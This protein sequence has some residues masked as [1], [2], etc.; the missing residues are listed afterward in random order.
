M[1][2][3]PKIPYVM[4]KDKQQTIAMGSINYSKMTQDGD[5]ADSSGISGRYFPYI[6]TAKG[7]SQVATTDNCVSATIFDE[8][9]AQVNEAGAL[10]YDGKLVGQLE[11]NE[12]Q[13]AAINTKLVIMPDKRY[14]DISGDKPVLKDMGAELFV[15]SPVFTENSLDLGNYYKMAGKVEI[16]VFD[17]FDPELRFCA[18][19]QNNVQSNF[20]IGIEKIPEKDQWRIAFMK[21]LFY[22]RVS[23]KSFGGDG[24]GTEF[25][26][27]DI[28]NTQISSPHEVYITDLD[29][30]KSGWYFI[31][32]DW[33][34]SGTYTLDKE[35]NLLSTNTVLDRKLQMWAIDHRS[36]TDM[37]TTGIRKMKIGGRELFVNVENAGDPAWGDYSIYVSCSSFDGSK[38]TPGI[39][40]VEKM[41]NGGWSGDFTNIMQ[42]DFIMQLKFDS[43]CVTGKVLTGSLKRNE[44]ALYGLNEISET[45][46][47]VF[48]KT[49]TLNS[50]VTLSEMGDNLLGLNI[51]VPGDTVIVTEPPGGANEFSFRIDTISP[52]GKTCYASSNVFKAMHFNGPIKI[53][54]RIPN[55]DYICEHDNRLYG[56]SIADNMIYASAMGDP[57]NFYAYTGLTTGSET[58]V[59]ASEGQFTACCPYDGGVMF[60]KSDKL[61]KLLGSSPLEYAIYTYNIDGVQQGSHK[62]LQNINEV[63][64][65]KGDRGVFAFDGSPRLISENFGDKHFESAV[66]GSN[67]ERYYVSMIDKDDRSHFFSYNTRTGLWVREGDRKVSS[68]TRSGKDA[69]MLESGKIKLYGAEETPMDA[70][71]YIQFTPIY[72]TIEGKKSY[73]RIK[74]RAHLPRGSYMEISVRCDG[75]RWAECGK[76]VGKREGIVPVMVPVNRC[77]KFELK[78]SGKGPCTIHSILREYYVGGDR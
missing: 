61:H 41:D 74:L 77:D 73:S 50:V 63:L 28:D 20:Y 53:E 8:K 2:K 31:S 43:Y 71:W 14:L 42:G 51:F 65:Y 5:V 64:Y 49:R 7:D 76:V 75:D 44:F 19:E 60:W 22:G 36:S 1:L 33:R 56:C 27:E 55:M 39:H 12:K 29:S 26:S 68:F 11:P 30:G 57:T 16:Y 15:T 18:V 6:T 10:Y 52:D 23:F 67:G 40:F 45:G 37:L 38:L 3:L 21:D 34:N 17:E 9:W 4:E 69:Y 25:Y 13:F 58:F 54:R 35:Y 62:S 70:E 78:I 59:V 48:D 47:G 46:S 66:G 32:Y 24:K 72:E